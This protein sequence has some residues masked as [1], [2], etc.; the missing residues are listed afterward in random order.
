MIHRLY[1]IVKKWSSLQMIWISLT[2]FLISLALINGKPF[3]VAQLKA[4]TGGV[5]ILDM[6]P[7]YSPQQA[8]AHLAALG[9]QGRA[10]DLHYI[11][12]QDMVFPAFYSFFYIITT[13][14]LFRKLFA[15]DHPLQQLSLLTLFGGLADYCENLCMLTMLLNYPTQLTAVA[16]IA[17]VFTLAKFGGIGISYSLLLIG[18]VGVSV[19]SAR[20]K[21][22]KRPT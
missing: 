3:G 9:D 10:F 2:C 8:Y 20:R 21:S 5:G 7:G 19:K 1:N 18:L 12:P 16:K 11:V 15:E 14:Y 6:E 17:N 4:I 22:G 13:I